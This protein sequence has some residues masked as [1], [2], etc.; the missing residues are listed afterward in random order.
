M[1]LTRQKARSGEN[2]KSPPRTH[3]ETNIHKVRTP[4]RTAF[5][6]KH[7]GLFIEQVLKCSQDMDGDELY[8]LS[9]V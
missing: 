6:H 8:F 9:L 2:H 1:V 4:S 5:T 7:N 3:P